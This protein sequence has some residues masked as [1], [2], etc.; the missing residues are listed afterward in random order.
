MPTA[1]HIVHNV[2]RTLLNGLCGRIG[3]RAA[4]GSVGQQMPHNTEPFCGGSKAGRQD[5]DLVAARHQPLHV[6]PGPV[7]G[8][9]A[10]LVQGLDHNGSFQGWSPR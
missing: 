5:V 4:G 2:G 10:S 8:P 3:Q 1:A 6:L 7:F 9:A